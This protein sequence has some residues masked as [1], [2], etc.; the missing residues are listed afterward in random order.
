MGFLNLIKYIKEVKIINK[1]EINRA[2]Q[3]M[4]KGELIKFRW[5]NEPD[6]VSYLEATTLSRQDV[7]NEVMNNCKYD[8]PAQ[9]IIHTVNKFVKNVKE[10][11]ER[12]IFN[13]GELAKL[14]TP[15][16][17]VQKTDQIL[18]EHMSRTGGKYI[19][20]FPPEPNGFLHIGH[21]KSL[22]LNFGY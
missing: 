22:F 3:L 14:H 4:E 1:K 15:F 10:K 21:A 16:T 17:N 12:N 19:T 13:E 8:M 5:L 20:R 11:K 9:K 2:M 6:L 7:L 18:E